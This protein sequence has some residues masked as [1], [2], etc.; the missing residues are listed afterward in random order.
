MSIKNELIEHFEGLTLPE[1]L[2]PLISFDDEV[3]SDA[4][5]SEGFEFSIDQ[6]KL[7]LKTYSESKDFLNSIYEFA[8]AD[9]SGSSYGFWL[10]DGNRNLENAPIV[11]FGSEG[12][13]H[14]VARN[15]NELLQI[16][17][18]DCEPMIE[19]DS[20]CYYR[21][22]DDYEP[23]E[24]RGEYCAWLKVRGIDQTEDADEIVKEAQQEYQES[25]SNWFSK[26]YEY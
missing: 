10:K 16:L 8:S 7:G 2:L 5:F 24:H 17:T 4:Y 12:G 13:Y 1:N 3:A 15:F 14:V 26:Y 21:D 6:E 9:A 22:P 18:F 11:A 23:S 19:W 20:V 25:F